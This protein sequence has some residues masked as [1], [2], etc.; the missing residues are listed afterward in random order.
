M[1]K[2]SLLL[3]LTVALFSADADAQWINRVKPTTAP[4][5]SF[6][7]AIGSDGVPTSSTVLSRLPALT[8]DVSSSAGSA[9][10]TVNKVQGTSPGTG[11]VSAFGTSLDATG[12]L[13]SF[14]KSM[15]HV[16]TNAALAAA[17][18]A[19]YPNG[20][21]RDDYSS[22]AGAGPLYFTVQSG[23]CAA[24]GYVDDGG[25]CVNS[26]DSNSWLAMY[27]SRRNVKQFGA[28][29]NGTGA[30]GVGTD[31]STAMQAAITAAQLSGVVIELP[32]G[33]CRVTTQL[34]ITKRITLEGVGAGNDN[35]DMPAATG[36]IGV[37]AT[38]A[39]CLFFDHTGVGLY[40]G[41]SSTILTAQEVRLERFCF[42]RKQPAF[43]TTGSWTPTAADYDLYV[44]SADVLTRDV[45]FW[46]ATKAI[47]VGGGTSNRTRFSAQGELRISAYDMAVNLDRV[48]DNVD[49]NNLRIYP[50][51]GGTPGLYPPVANYRKAHQ[52]GIRMAR[53]DG[54]QASNTFIFGAYK[55]V[56]FEAVNPKTS[57][58]DIPS[59]IQFGR[60]YTDNNVYSIYADTFDQ[61]MLQ[62]TATFA[63]ASLNSAVS[64]T[65]TYGIYVKHNATNDTSVRLRFGKLDI[66]NVD[67][68]PIY[69]GGTGYINIDDFV[70]KNYDLSSGG[71][72]AIYLNSASSS[73]RIGHTTNLNTTPGVTFGGGA[74]YTFGASNFNVGKADTRTLSGTPVFATMGDATFTVNSQNGTVFVR[75]GVAHFTYNI[76][77]TT[78]AY[79]T[80]SGAFSI[81][82]NTP[83]PL[84]S[85]SPITLGQFSNVTL[86]ALA[87]NSAAMTSAGIALYA[88]PSGGA[89]TSWSKTNIPA[90]T[91]VTMNFAGNYRTY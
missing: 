31:D 20:V 88:S 64:D 2:G 25:Q 15:Q 87:Y 45:I 10:V 65:G 74:G 9:S 63:D 19:T 4:A 54:V 43:V 76:N 58:Q 28:A 47:F 49:W 61:S 40:V 38:N 79:T 26:S 59:T 35:S 6:L 50:F 53:V 56:S 67:Q 1:K 62:L 73:V 71:L 34:N 70:L 12:G 72:A 89:T 39:S 90:S 57:T 82:L 8:G 36:A 83:A 33:F 48:N 51:D 55:G 42:L 68:N 11:V 84:V 37:P 81:N 23:T 77:F 44:Y 17:S 80:P 78:N 13:A 52:V 5:D 22:G 27:G 41:S 30:T 86:G 69:F 21:W 3:A 29:C 18:T 60:V 14:T 66:S 46:N 75:D 91:T 7:T 24:N 32:K 16:A 85:A